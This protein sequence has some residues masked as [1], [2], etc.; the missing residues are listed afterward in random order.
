MDNLIKK[1]IYYNCEQDEIGIRIFNKYREYV[2][3]ENLWELDSGD[4]MNCRYT[5]TTNRQAG[6]MGWVLIGS[7]YE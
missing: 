2:H 7:I 6:K 5:F 1:L 4:H 3:D